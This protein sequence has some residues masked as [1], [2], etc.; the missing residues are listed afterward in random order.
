VTVSQRADLPA[1]LTVA[2]RVMAIV[3]NARD[4]LALL[5]RP[6]VFPPA[7]LV[8]TRQH[9]RVVGILAALAVVAS[10]IFID[11]RAYRLALR[12]PT[13]VVDAFYE[14][15]DFGRSGWVLVPTGA[16]IAVLA[17][18]AS[19][20]L[21]HMTRGVLAAIATRVGFV[22]LAVGVPGLFV[23]IVKRFIGRVRPSSAGPFAYEPF[24]WCPDFASLPS[25][26]TTTAFATLVAVGALFPRA[27]PFLWGFA[28]LIA[29][30]RVVVTAHFVSDVL[31]GAA[32]GALGA[33]C[34]RDWFALRRLG[35]VVTR[36]GGVKALPGPSAGRIKRV[37]RTLIGP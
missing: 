7:W 30:S 19:P 13:G 2:G 4:A 22:F 21:D 34:V 11:E 17:L 25:G 8:A 31:A 1:D 35:F 36:D 33:W 23:A 3:E 29:L 15:T 24:H 27:R 20:A 5:L 32:V 18:V 12:L 10:M 28:L 6:P 26:H 16:L 14:I 37:A 9:Y